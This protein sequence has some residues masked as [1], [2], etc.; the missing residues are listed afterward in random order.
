M[1]NILI[2]SHVDINAASMYPGNTPLHL[3][4]RMKNQLAVKLL[5]QLDAKLI[6]DHEDNTPADLAI[7]QGDLSTYLILHKAYNL[8]IKN[9]LAFQAD[10]HIDQTALDY[11]IFTEA[12]ETGDVSKVK[13]IL[14]KFKKTDLKLL[15]NLLVEE[16]YLGLPPLSVAIRKNYPQLFKLLLRFGANPNALTNRNASLFHETD[17]IAY[18]ESHSKKMFVD[19]LSRGADI[20]TEGKSKLWSSIIRNKKYDFLIFMLKEWK[21]RNTKSKFEY[22]VKKSGELSRKLDAGYNHTPV[23]TGLFDVI[24]EII[25]YFPTSAAFLEM[26]FIFGFDIHCKDKNNDTLITYL[27]SKKFLINRFYIDYFWK[28]GANFNWKFINCDYALIIAKRS[29]DMKALDSGLLVATKNKN[30]KLVDCLIKIPDINFGVVDKDQNTLL[31][32]AVE[33]GNLC[34]L[35][36]FLAQGINPNIQNKK[37][38]TP[39]MLAISRNNIAASK[40]L[41]KEKLD[42]NL[43]DSMKKTVWAYT[44]MIQSEKDRSEIRN[45]ITCHHISNLPLYK[46]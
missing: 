3:A 1:I 5:I 16:N 23:S 24:C 17:V 39:L 21:N 18:K 34:H 42:L 2:S 46:T 40:L 15:K 19:L 12:V 7:R 30:S 45:L 36:E 14:Q 33:T 8:P 20:F 27:A 13:L 25:T 43:V 26:F 10:S 28:K 11:S 37:G 31:H 41:I 29:V 22:E 35:E 44:G 4:V 9:L 32:I 6:I 38:I